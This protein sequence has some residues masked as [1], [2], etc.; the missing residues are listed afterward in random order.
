M[1]KGAKFMKKIIGMILCFV[2]AISLCACGSTTDI[3]IDSNEQASSYT[4]NPSNKT[5]STESEITTGIE[6]LVDKN[7]SPAGNIYDGIS[8]QGFTTEFYDNYTCRA[9][10]IKTGELKDSEEWKF[11]GDGKI[12][13]YRYDYFIYNDYLVK[14]NSSSEW[15]ILEGDSK[16][17]YTNNLTNEGDRILRKDGTYEYVTKYW[18]YKGTY[19]MID[20]RVIY[21]ESFDKADTEPFIIYLLIDNDNALHYAYPKVN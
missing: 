4:D 10:W 16:N 5:V 17:G 20:E 11:I 13:R 2:L 6:G 9:T 14:L 15:G 7:G 18:S 12:R 19:K 8:G 21:I 3:D 1:K